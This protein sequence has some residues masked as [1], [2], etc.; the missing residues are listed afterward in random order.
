MSIEQ[1]PTRATQERLLLSYLSPEEKHH[2][3]GSFVV[4]DFWPI[5][6]KENSDSINRFRQLAK[7]SIPE[8]IEA[9]QDVWD[10]VIDVNKLDDEFVYEG[11]RRN[12]VLQGLSLEE[13][14]L[15]NKL[16]SLSLYSELEKD[17]LMAL[18]KTIL[19]ELAEDLR[20]RYNLSDDEYQLLMTPSFETFFVKYHFD[21]FEYAVNDNPDTKAGQ[22]ED[23]IRN[24]HANDPALFELRYAEMQFPVGG[25]LSAVFAM[26]KAGIAQRAAMKA[27]FISGRADFV[28]FEKLLE[29]DNFLDFEY[30]YNLE[31]CPE[32]YV[33]K[34]LFAA[35]QE[36][37]IFA[38]VEKP[39]RLQDSEF[40]SGVN[41]LIRLREQ[42]YVIELGPGTDDDTFADIEEVLIEGSKEE[43]LR[44]LKQGSPS[45]GRRSE[46]DV[47]IVGYEGE[48]LLART[49]EGGLVAVSDEEFDTFGEFVTFQKYDRGM[50]EGL[51]QSIDGFIAR[52]P[53]LDRTPYEH[54]F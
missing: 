22:R 33:R 7:E 18:N 2:L 40:I 12:S 17:C 19:G 15:A 39:L 4:E 25:D 24:F 47:M 11:L 34:M 30:R 43:V 50:I 54:A 1:T 52:R 37:G 10:Y 20:A 14:T 26:Q 28:A 13:L 38:G 53:Y 6:M 36:A 31:A 45:M 49:A 23:L 27:E 8:F 9:Y 48:T 29:Y 41:E 44:R 46:G 51:S 16:L 3:V 5:F 32:Y 21:H 42:S 35:C